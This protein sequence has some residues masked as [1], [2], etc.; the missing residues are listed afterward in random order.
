[1]TKSGR[2]RSN[3]KDPLKKV[4][5]PEAVLREGGYA[6]KDS[7]GVNA[8]EKGKRERTI[9]GIGRYGR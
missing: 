1:M 6:L 7:E 5:E 8:D 3:A 9:K 2:K 4:P